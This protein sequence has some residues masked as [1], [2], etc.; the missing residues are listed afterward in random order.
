MRLPICA[1]ATL[2]ASPAFANGSM[3]C[4]GRPYSAEVQ[5][6]LTTGELTELV[7][8]RTDGT[9][10]ASERF[11]L[12]QRFVDHKRQVMH[13]TGTS[14]EDASRTLTLNVSMARGTLTYAGVQRRLRC[15]WSQLG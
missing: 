13:I 4:E 12:R 2:I 10:P 8:A 7:V 15:D 14:L 1:L 6:R 11:A 5:F 9:A 3:Q